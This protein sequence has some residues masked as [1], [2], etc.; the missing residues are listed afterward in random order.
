M[1]E[2]GLIKF[3]L[4]ENLPKAEICPQ[5]L[6][7][8]ERQLKNRDLVMTYLVMVAGFATAIVV[9]VSEVSLGSTIPKLGL[10]YTFVFCRCSSE[11]LTSAS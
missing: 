4:L 8:T 11:Y 3:K 6:G 9:F 2:G 7:G 5:N 1:V 10:K